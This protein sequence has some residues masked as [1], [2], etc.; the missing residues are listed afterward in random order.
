MMLPCWVESFR[1][2]YSP[3]SVNCWDRYD[4]WPRNRWRSL[5]AKAGPYLPIPAYPVSRSP[6][7]RLASLV[8]LTRTETR[9]S[10][11][12]WKSPVPPE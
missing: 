10:T 1:A 7:T 2:T 12:L 5:P 9:A 8:G 6:P 11:S 3:A 4:T